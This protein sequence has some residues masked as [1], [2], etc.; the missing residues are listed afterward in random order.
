MASDPSPGFHQEF[1]EFSQ[2]A[3]ARLGLSF[4]TFAQAW[5]G[6]YGTLGKTIDV[7]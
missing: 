1:G 5:K 4:L 6:N 2:V 3:S 7:A